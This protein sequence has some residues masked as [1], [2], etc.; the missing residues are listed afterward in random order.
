MQTPTQRAV[1][2]KADGGGR[3]D[4]DMGVNP[5]VVKTYGSWMLVSRKNRKVD[6]RHDVMGDK[7]SM[8]D[9]WELRHICMRMEM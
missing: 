6:K 3:R 4:K 8:H 7:D 2:E 1:M 5:E 9:S